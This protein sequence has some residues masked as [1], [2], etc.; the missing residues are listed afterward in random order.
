MK[1]LG[2]VT[3]YFP[4]LIELE[5]NI[6][7][8]IDGIEMLII[9][10][11]TPKEQSR[12]QELALKLSNPKIQIKT[13]GKNEFLAKAFNESV[14]CAESMDYTHLLTMDQDS[15]FVTGNFLRFIE[16]VAENNDEEI[17]IFAPIVNSEEN[18]KGKIVETESVITSGSIHTIDIFKKVGYYRED[19]MI[20]MV[21]VDFCL[22]LRKFGAK[23]VCF[24]EIE[25]KHQLGYE[26]TGKLGFKINPYSAQSTY[27][28]V[29]NNL[30]MWREYPDNFSM[31]T[32]Y[33]FVKYKIVYR[34][35]KLIFEPDTLRKIKAIFMGLFHGIIGKTG[36]Y[37]I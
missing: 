22:K 3:T 13:T 32:R 11:N 21:D 10:E 9:W 12:I 2:I 29:R 16:L 36:E 17:G 23:I 35:L 31:Q 14:K 20:H 37:T 4:N 19:L 8:Y 25:L 15:S 1:I 18:K 27:Y 34:I 28:I 7:T 5:Y 24:P 30:I 26:Q 6:S 33:Y